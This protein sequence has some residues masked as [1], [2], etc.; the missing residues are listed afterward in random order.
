MDRVRSLVN[1][2][3]HSSSSR[4]RNNHNQQTQT[5][6]HEGLNFTDTDQNTVFGDDAATLHTTVSETSTLGDLRRNGYINRCPNFTWERNM[7]FVTTV[8]GKGV[9]CFPSEESFSRFRA[10]KRRLD[11][12]DNDEGLGIPL[13]HAI[14]M[15]MLRSI[16]NKHLPIMKF[17]RYVLTKEGEPA[18]MPLKEGSCELISRNESR[19][20]YK[21]ELCEV[22]KRVN[23]K[24]G[25]VTHKFVFRQ[26]D[27]PNTIFSA[28]MANHVFRRDTDARVGDL[29]LRWHGT[30][31]LASPFGSGN[32]K[33]LV[34]DDGMPS[35][36]DQHTDESYDD[37]R[38]RA[39]PLRLV[40]QLPVWATYSDE[41]A[42]IIPSKRTLRQA[43]FLIGETSE[44]SLGLNN[45]P[46]DT[47]VLTCMCMTL[48]D[49]ESRKD[50]RT[51]NGRGIGIGSFAPSIAGMPIN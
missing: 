9:F 36:L 47:V 48:H 7:P 44:Q 3:N 29:N 23:S 12:L 2:S 19:V 38:R 40:Q 10:N 51:A 1:R 25:H 28:I 30:T 8:L 5:G 26:G 41:T 14:S 45:V 43:N 50:K 16:L 18:P 15:G 27:G 6:S 17:Y 46:W 33:L 49:F 34:L 39:Q 35:L 31:G 11:V 24:T 21:I 42:T 13:L 20:L 4:S 37:A 32:F 22:Y